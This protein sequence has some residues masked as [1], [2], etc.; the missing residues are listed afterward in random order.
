M[1]KEHFT[2]HQLISF[3]ITP[4]LF[5]LDFSRGMREGETHL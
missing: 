5:N 1:H 4:K 3:R 2:F